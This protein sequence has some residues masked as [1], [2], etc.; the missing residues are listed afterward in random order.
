MKRREIQNLSRNYHQLGRTTTRAHIRHPQKAQDLNLNSSRRNSKSSR[1]WRPLIM[2][3][4]WRCNPLASEL[5][6]VFIA[7][8]DCWRMSLESSSSLFFMWNFIMGKRLNGSMHC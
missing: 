5:V 1:I 3:S 2:L 8:L 7:F 4:L 6:R